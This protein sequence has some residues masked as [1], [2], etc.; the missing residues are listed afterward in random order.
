[1]FPDLGTAPEVLLCRFADVAP[2]QAVRAATALRA[3]GRRV[4][5]FPDTPALGKQLQYA[6]TIGARFAGILGQSE[7]ELGSLTLK[8]L[9]SGEQRT[10]PLDEAAATIARWP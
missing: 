9:G 5:V 2:A 10:V 4:E 3:G 8:H 7:I 1:M 6:T